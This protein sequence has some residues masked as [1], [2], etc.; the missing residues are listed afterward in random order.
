VESTVIY[1]TISFVQARAKYLS[2]AK[3]MKAYEDKL[4]EAWKDNVEMVLPS[5]LKRNL[6]IKPSHAQP[7]Q[8]QQANEELQGGQGQWPNY[9][10]LFVHKISKD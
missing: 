1:T 4:Y 9:L 10:F 8:I 6:L 5:L 7:Q 2:V 3:Q